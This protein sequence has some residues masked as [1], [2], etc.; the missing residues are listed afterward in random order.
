[1][2]DKVFSYSEKNGSIS[3]DASPEQIAALNNIYQWQRYLMIEALGSKVSPSSSGVMNLRLSSL[4]VQGQRFEEW[5]IDG[6]DKSAIVVF[7]GTSTDILG[8][9]PIS[10][11]RADFEK[12]LSKTAFE[13]VMKGQT[14][15]FT[16]YQPL[17]TTALGT[18][19]R[20]PLVQDEERVILV[21]RF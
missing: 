4:G 13:R 7:R 9:A 21:N 20:T 8:A 11:P 10:D 15:I 16:G 14:I 5:H 19:H 17:D 18:V 1:M 6:G 3:H 12:K 2:N